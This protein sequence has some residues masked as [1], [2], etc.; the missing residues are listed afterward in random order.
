VKERKGERERTKIKEERMCI[1]CKSMREGK[2]E[3]VYVWGGGECVC[4]ILFM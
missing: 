3:C 4:V 2:C 1:M